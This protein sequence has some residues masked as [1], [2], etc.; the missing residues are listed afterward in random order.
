[1]TEPTHTDR[2]AN[3]PSHVAFTVRDVGTESFWDRVGVAW[4]SRDGKGYTVQLSAV[5]LDGKI[6]LRPN[7]T[8]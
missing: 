8:K 6:V 3:R 7:D 4:A 1:M 2:S 5:P